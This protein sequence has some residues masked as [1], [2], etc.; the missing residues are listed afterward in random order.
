MSSNKSV[1]EILFHMTSTVPLFISVTLGAWSLGESEWE[2][3][4]TV[5]LAAQLVGC[6]S[7]TLAASVWYGVCH[8]SV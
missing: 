1:T 3:G 7:V 5:V 8:G 4:E 6:S 2:N